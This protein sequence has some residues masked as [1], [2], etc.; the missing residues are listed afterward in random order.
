MCTHMVVYYRMRTEAAEQ[1]AEK[2][3]KQGK[4]RGRQ[5]LMP[6]VVA[7]LEEMA[8]VPDDHA[9]MEL[10]NDG[11]SQ[12]SQPVPAAPPPQAMAPPPPQL[13]RASTQASHTHH[14]CSMCV[15]TSSI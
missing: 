9:M 14:V 7:A 8:P 12:A 10:F 6:E 3:A 15:T 2:A 11:S 5:Q 4:G 13:Q 1:A